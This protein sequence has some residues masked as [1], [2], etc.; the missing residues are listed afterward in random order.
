MA[1][2]HN[3]R[4]VRRAD[5]FPPA[6]RLPVIAELPDPFLRPD[7]TRMASPREWNAQRRW[8]LRSILHYQYGALP[9]AP[10]QERDIVPEVVRS[11][12]L[13]ALGA[14][15][16]TIRLAMGRQHEIPV[17]L[18]LTVPAGAGPFPVI[19]RG[20]L[21][22]GK[23]KPRIVAAVIER[24][25]VLADFDRTDIARDAPEEDRV[26]HAYPQ[27]DG[28]RIAAWAWAFHRVIDYLQTLEIVDKARIAVTGHS[29]GGKAALLAGAIDER[30]AL[31]APNNS[32]CGG[33]G[34]YRLQAAGSEDI[35]AI[36][37]TFPYWFHRRFRQF[38]GKVNRLTFDQHT[39]KALVAPRALLTTEALGDVWANPKGTQQS[40]AAA[41]EVFAFMGA[42]DRLGIRFREG[43]HKHRLDDWIALLDF[44]DW[45]FFGKTSFNHSAF[46]DAAAGFAWKAPRGARP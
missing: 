28:G 12:A 2:P 36:T 31:T 20:D 32:G 21:G 24:G 3:S 19:V 17:R 43:P 29:R 22:W 38:V 42:E 45:Q 1:F 23:T 9:P 40:H 15:Q 10:R 8:L 41:R 33:A 13:P 39:V 5:P 37:T 27:F 16:M 7:G 25:Y 30:I 11:V 6:S 18:I 46:P 35:A 4:T 44:A 14:K 26:Y 34:C